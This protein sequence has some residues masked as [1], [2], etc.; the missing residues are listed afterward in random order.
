MPNPCGPCSDSPESFST[1]RLYFGSVFLDTVF[2]ARTTAVLFAAMSLRNQLSEI[3]GIVTNNRRP[4]TIPEVPGGARRPARAKLKRWQITGSRGLKSGAEAPTELGVSRTCKARWRGGYR[5]VSTPT[6]PG[7]GMPTK[8]ASHVFP[9][10]R[11]GR[12]SKLAFLTLPS[13]G[14]GRRRRVRSATCFAPLE[15]HE[16]PPRNVFAEVGDRLGDHLADGHGLVLDVVLFVEAI[17][18]VELFH[19]PVDDPLDDLLRLSGGLGLLAIDVALF[20]QHLRGDLF[21]AQVPRIDRRDVHGDVVTQLLERFGARHE[22]GLA[23]DFH[24]HADFS[25]GVNVMADEPLG[26][27]TLRFLGGSGLAFFPQDIDGLFDVAGRFHQRRAA[28]AETRA[29]AFA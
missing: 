21:T 6:A 13:H 14:D 22:V 17:L 1:M 16:A 10:R 9:R 27:L 28:I 19:L 5:V 26:R 2:V 8:R 20:R 7:H 25:A 23:I 3:L 12:S 18:L 24:D 29:G 4:R 15:A 11:S